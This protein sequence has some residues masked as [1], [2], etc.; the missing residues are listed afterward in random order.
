MDWTKIIFYI[1]IL[2]AL[3]IYV[4]LSQLQFNGVK[5][6]LVYR[7]LLALFFPVIF[8]LF[9]LIGSILIGIILT[10]LFIIGLWIL[11]IKLKHKSKIPSFLKKRKI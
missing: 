7:I 9:L 8:L 3:F 11:I 6:K 5:I 10:I 4:K 1:F 2:I